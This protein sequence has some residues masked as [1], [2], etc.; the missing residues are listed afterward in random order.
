MCIRDSLTSQE[1]QNRLKGIS[2][3]SDKKILVRLTFDYHTQQDMITRNVAIDSLV[4]N[5]EILDSSN[6]NNINIFYP[7]N[8]EVFAEEVD[9]FFRNKVPNNVSG[10]IISLNDQPSNNLLSNL[11]TADYYMSSVGQTVSPFLAHGTENNYIGGT[12]VMGYQQYLSLI[13]I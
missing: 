11:K 3:D 7:D 13:H 4:T 2:G 5:N 8:Q 6:A 1:E 10:K 9:I 12:L